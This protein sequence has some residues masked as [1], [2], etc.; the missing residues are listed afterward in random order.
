MADTK[1]L[2]RVPCIRV[3]RWKNAMPPSFSGYKNI[4]VIMKSHCKKWYPLSPYSLK[5]NDIIFE[6]YYQ[7]HKVYEKV[8]QSKQFYSRWNKTVIWDYIEEVHVK[9]NEIQKEYFD[10][11]ETGFYNEYPVRYPVGFS[12]RGKCL[13]SLTADGRKLNYIQARK[14]IYLKEYCHLVR[15]TKEFNDLKKLMEKGEKL[16]II[17]PDG[18]H[19]ESI[20][21]YMDKY[22]VDRTFI[23]KDTILVTEKNMNII[24]NDQKHPFGHGYCLAIALLDLDEKIK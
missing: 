9:N 3:G 1:I 2:K 15:K 17:E 21:Y 19:Q 10:W 16:L 14:E 7:F 18:P 13:F 23:E 5:N 22:E 20:G 8:P 12:S 6:N 24:L 4:I 11:R